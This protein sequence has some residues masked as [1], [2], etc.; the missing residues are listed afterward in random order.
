MFEDK[1]Q[2]GINGR[3]TLSDRRYLVSPS[4]LVTDEL[5][6]RC[7]FGAE[8]ERVSRVYSCLPFIQSNGF[9]IL[10][11]PLRY[12]TQINTESRLLLVINNL[13]DFCPGSSIRVE[14]TGE[15][16]FNHAFSKLNPYNL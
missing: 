12:S 5:S 4:L 11:Q 9:V 16:F 6:I 15:I 8:R 1:R 7:V 2:A 10:Q 3:E 14:C 13:L